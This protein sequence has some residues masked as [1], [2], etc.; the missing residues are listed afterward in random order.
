MSLGLLFVLRFFFLLILFS[1]CLS[2]LVHVNDETDKKSGR[3]AKAQKRSFP[4]IACLST[5]LAVSVIIEFFLSTKSTSTGW[6]MIITGAHPLGFV[7]LLL[8]IAPVFV[9]AHLF[10]RNIWNA[11]SKIQQQTL[12]KSY[13]SFADHRQALDESIDKLEQL[14]KKYPLLLGNR[15][16]DAKVELE[17]QRAKILDSF[18]LERANRFMEDGQGSEALR[19]LNEW[20]PYCMESLLLAMEVPSLPECSRQVQSLSEIAGLTPRQ[21]ALLATEANQI[22]ADQGWSSSALRNDSL[23]KLKGEIG[24]R[25]KAFVIYNHGDQ[26]V[27][28]NLLREDPHACFWLKDF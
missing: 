9:A 17:K 13:D 18:N 14:E 19:A 2:A 8:S 11:A 28:Q 16:A 10:S 6:V 25:R 26:K 23:D 20:K 24:I 4:W 5:L 21:R 12:D 22:I 1:V 15:F 27:A 7:T 3:Y